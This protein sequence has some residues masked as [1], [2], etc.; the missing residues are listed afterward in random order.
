MS[1]KIDI[2]QENNHMNDQAQLLL[3]DMIDKRVNRL[4]K[5]S[6]ESMF[7]GRVVTEE[8][9][10]DIVW[11]INDNIKSENKLKEHFK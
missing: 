1:L 4:L 7:S 11:A 8:T 10:K 3:K 6:M 5:I 2:A 9:S